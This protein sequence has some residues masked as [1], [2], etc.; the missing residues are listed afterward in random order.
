MSNDCTR[1]S[2]MAFDGVSSMELSLKRHPLF[3]D[4]TV[5][6]RC[7]YTLSALATPRGCVAKSRA[8]P[9]FN[10]QSGTSVMG[11]ASWFAPPEK[12][13]T[14]TF[15]AAQ[16]VGKS[17]RSAFWESSFEVGAGDDRGRVDA[18][19]FGTSDAAAFCARP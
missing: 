16:L 5:I 10:Q 17:S 3:R 13:A 15:C 4:Y 2:P 7:R 14:M 9:F 12:P 18:T 8:F 19:P 6:I 1:T 11:L